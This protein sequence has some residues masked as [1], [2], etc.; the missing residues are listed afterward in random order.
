MF[1]ILY[2]LVI[3][4]STLFAI[5]FFGYGICSDAEFKRVIGERKKLFIANQQAKLI[6]LTAKNGAK[7]QILQDINDA[8]KVL[9]KEI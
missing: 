1:E 5:K 7:G 4:F 2:I 8:C 6:L 9:S 3:V